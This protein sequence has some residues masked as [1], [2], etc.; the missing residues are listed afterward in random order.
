MNNPDL[1][2]LPANQLNHDGS[3]YD[4]YYGLSRREYAAIH[5]RVADSGAQWL[6]KMIEASIRNKLAAQ[7]MQAM[8]TERCSNPTRI[9]EH[10]ATAYAWADEII[11]RSKRP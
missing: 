10:A 6:D 4:Q 1:P 3:V 7:A 11:A 9:R 8:E 5:L 2:A